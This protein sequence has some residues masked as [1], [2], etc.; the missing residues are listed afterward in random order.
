MIVPSSG[1]QT[2]AA[3]LAEETGETLAT[4]TFERFADGELL[5]AVPGF[6]GETA[7][8]VASTPRDAD[9][10]ELLQLQDAVREAGA[11]EVVT[12][13]PYLGYA[14]QDRAFKPGQPVSVRAMAR[15]V[16][17][18]TDRVVLV[19]PHEP[20][21]REFF[22]VPVELVDAAGALA[23]PLPDLSD[24][25][26]LSPDASAIGIAETVRDA[27]GSGSTD[28]FEKH[29]DREDGTVEVSPS[30][31]PVS[32]RDVVVVDDIIATGSTMSQ[33]IAV[34][35]ERGAERVFAACVHPV[36][37]SNA[38]SKLRSAGVERIV[39]T[40]T[41]ERACSEVSAAAAI[42]DAL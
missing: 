5:A 8:V 22:E 20:A 3:T 15:A 25:L 37:A 31:A 41:L 30:D 16:S 34:L 9:W 17:T 23:D 21:V 12:V 24:P 39:G 27:H 10:I 2:L 11:D 14:R 40:D 7:A 42:A 32:G 26:F 4:P 6:E 18:G 13:I 19:N 35:D 33:S 1:S 36:L 29:R 28:Y 38:V